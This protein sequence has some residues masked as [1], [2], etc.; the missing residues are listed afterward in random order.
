MRMAANFTEN[1]EE[2]E[3]NITRCSATFD[4]LVHEVDL[5]TYVKHIVEKKTSKIIKYLNGIRFIFF[6]WLPKFEKNN[7]RYRKFILIG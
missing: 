3:W 4:M 6:S 1:T 2:N 7:Y 5:E